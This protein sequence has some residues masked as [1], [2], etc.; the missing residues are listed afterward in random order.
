MKTHYKF[1]HFAK[2]EDFDTAWWCHNN[3]TGGTLGMVEWYRPWKQYI[4]NAHDDS[5]F[6]ADCLQD[7]I[8][9]MSQLES[10]PSV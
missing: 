1:I 4:F 7:I 9:F 3:R 10:P 5:L 2:H 6:S 8:H